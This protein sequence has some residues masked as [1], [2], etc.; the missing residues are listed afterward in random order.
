VKVSC[1]EPTLDAIDALEGIDAF[2]L[3]VASDERPLS[4]A[5]GYLDWRLL[6][7]LS[8]VLLQGFF[9]GDL[10][11]KLL[12]PTQG[13]VPPVKAFA[14]GVGPGASVDVGVLEE[15]LDQAAQVLKKAGVGSVAL[16]LPEA[17]KVSDAGR[18]EAV[19]GKFAPGFGGQ[20]VLLADKS[21]RQALEK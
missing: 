16:A 21:V 13:Q 20:V 9:K 4:G 10:G 1:V 3:L 17:P 11:E 8:R 12:I 5:A 18:A 19:K 6:G 2:C 7:A 15:A 14:L